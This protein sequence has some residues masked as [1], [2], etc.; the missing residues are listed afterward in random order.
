MYIDEKDNVFF[1]ISCCACA[2]FSIK[3]TQKKMKKNSKKKKTGKD[4]ETCNL[5]QTKKRTKTFGNLFRKP[6]KG[7]INDSI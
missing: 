5:K 6:V 4:V 3:N 7:K 2:Y 1:L